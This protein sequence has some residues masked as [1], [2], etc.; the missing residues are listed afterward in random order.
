MRSLLGRLVDVRE[1]EGRPAFQ[2]AL[3][4]FLLIAGH[5]VLET[6]RDAL[7][8]QKL[9]PSRLTLVYVL[10]A[11]LA[12][13]AAPLCTALAR[14]FGRRNALVALLL[15]ASY[16][17]AL[18][19]VQPLGAPGVFALYAWSA[20]LGTVLV[21]QFWLFASELLTVSQGKRLY[22]PIAAGGVLG[23]VVGA[24]SAAGLLMRIRVPNLLLFGAACFLSAA[25]VLTTVWTEPL[26]V[27]RATSPGRHGW[28][29]VWQSAVDLF[30]EQPY[31][32]R[33]AALVS[34]SS[35]ALLALDYLFKASVTQHVA[36]ARL[37]SFFAG[38][39]AALNAA[40]LLAQL[41]VS[42]PLI[43]RLG[44]VPALGVL[45]AILFA[46]GGV[47]LF[48]GVSLFSVLALKA[49]DG[50]FRYSVHRVASELAEMPLAPRVQEQTKA[51][52]DGPLPRVAQ[53]LTAGLLLAL[54]AS[55]LASARVV[56]GLATAL[57]LGWL[58][59]VLGLRVPYLERLREAL[60]KP[61]FDPGRW[62]TELD[63]DSL[64]AVL[65]ALSSPQPARAI[66]AL[67]L[68]EEKQRVR[69][70]PALVLYH[71]DESVVLRALEI[72]G[73]SGRD[74]WLPHS[75]RLLAHASP[76]VRAAVLSALSRRG[77]HAALQRGLDDPSPLVRAYAL[78]WISN[79]EQVAE[80][81]ADARMQSLLELPG[82]EGQ[83]AQLALA[84]AVRAAPHP[85][86]TA[87]LLELARR[88]S[89]PF[90]PVAQAMAEIADPRFV[91]ILLPRLGL[92]EGRGA[93]RE[94]LV[95]LGDVALTALARA[96]DDR[97]TPERVRAHIPRTVSRFRSQAAADLLLDWL[98]SDRPGGL[99]YKALR[100]LGRV[101]AETRV[102]VDRARI[103]RQLRLNLIEYLRMLA[104]RQPLAAR[105]QSARGGRSLRLLIGLIDDKL[106]QSLERAF[107]LLQIRH[108]HENLRSV[109]FASR[110]PE[111]VR[112]AHALEF[113]DVLTARPA[114]NN[115]L[116][117][118][119]R[120]LVLLVVDDLS[121]AERLTRAAAFLPNPPT[122]YAAALAALV[123]DH[124]ESLA[125]FA[126]YHALEVGSAELSGAVEE[127]L[128]ERPAL[129]RA[130]GTSP[131][132]PPLAGA[133][134]AT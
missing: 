43:R 38:Y 110:S 115:L 17:T 85:R 54:S 103:D 120:Q 74:D 89:L 86:W 104:L 30:V 5:T 26:P 93:V 66:G 75:E 57:S 55:G 106:E 97:E 134:H 32:R 52:V 128:R 90:E 95:R 20:L 3:A 77:Q 24:S 33:L 34:L 2:A 15:L 12:L 51:F 70:I 21:L 16:G 107:R 124:D 113:L 65:E 109:Y 81:L 79:L 29:G 60:T 59:V 112:R 18:F 114:E 122:T 105:P 63:L 98:D 41:F 22:G 91:D 100:G 10:T 78:F 94:A 99:R 71:Q 125:A 50:T 96:F 40:S 47:T 62:L 9:A 117:Q 82:E 7:F 101:V 4:L 58:W 27:A 25:L 64:E 46:G 119:V 108:R 13:L 42:G 126:A 116:G 6:A 37:G 130:P 84:N 31:V 19:N 133:T 67:E 129:A 35:A 68:L 39:Y 92:R 45:P 28:R 83:Q 72:F 123:S 44:V 23:A 61:T 118:Q 132:F 1:G 53:A 80:P 87:L 88:D 49:S 56:A 76:A 36:A 14:R 48:A 102:R 69:L 131:L 121:V 73:A 8:L 111:R 127:A 11:A